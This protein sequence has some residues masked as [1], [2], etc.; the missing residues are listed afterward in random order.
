VFD[1]DNYIHLIAGHP[2]AR[3]K[4]FYLG[5]LS[6]SGP[7]T[8]D[9]PYGKSSAEFDECYRAIAAAIDALAEL[10]HAPRAAVSAEKLPN[11]TPGR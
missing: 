6:P 3:R 2:S 5:L 1:R 8:I 11:P 10:R 9:D 7:V 4:T